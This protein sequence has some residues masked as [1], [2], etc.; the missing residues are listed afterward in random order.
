MSSDAAAFVSPS[1]TSLLTAALR[2][3]DAAMAG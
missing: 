2:E 1:S 3:A